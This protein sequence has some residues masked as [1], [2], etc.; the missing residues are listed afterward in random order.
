MTTHSI[1]F[2][3]AANYYD[4]TR[5]LSEPMATQGLQLILDRAGPQARILEVGAGTGRI[6]VPLLQHGADWIGC[7]LSSEMMS[8]LRAK[9]PTARLA[10]TNAAQLPFVADRFDA[11][12]TIHVL[13]LV[14]PW[15]AALREIK[16]VLK[17]GGVYLNS[18]IWH[19]ETAPSRRLRNYWRER[20]EI[21]GASWQRPGLQSQE[22]LIAELR[23]LNATLETIEV[24]RWRTPSTL[25]EEID[26]LASRQFSESWNIPDDV[27]NM[28]LD[29]LRAWAAHEYGDLDQSFDEERRL[30]FEVI[31]F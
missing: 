1:S 10:Q 8:K 5:Q 6:G 30:I 15:R 22:E 24:A 4:Q 17:P 7:D 25:R 3:R 21:H 31:R 12:I 29:E 13:H 27:F 20:I 28:T 23:S 2:D 11:A 9:V 14:G 18:G 19:D 16:R 26:S